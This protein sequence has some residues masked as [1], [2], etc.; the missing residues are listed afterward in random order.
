MRA[1]HNLY[2]LKEGGLFFS[3]PIQGSGLGLFSN[4]SMREFCPL[5]ASGGI[6]PTDTLR[7]DSTLTPVT[8]EKSTLFIGVIKTCPV[9]SPKGGPA[10]REF[11]RV[12]KVLQS[13]SIYSIYHVRR[14]IA[15]S[16]TFFVFWLHRGVRL[17]YLK[18]L[19]GS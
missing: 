8:S 6:S 12:N 10:E 9:E 18:E 14:I 4:V 3:F 16:Y 11:H 17:L 1:L 19:Q 5:P 13:S 7:K 2:F 15:N